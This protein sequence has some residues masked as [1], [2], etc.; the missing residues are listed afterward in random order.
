[1]AVLRVK[2]MMHYTGKYFAAALGYGVVRGVYYTDKV[3]SRNDERM[4]F[5]TRIA[6]VIMCTCMAPLFSPYYLVEDLNHVDE[7]FFLK[8]RT[9]DTGDAFPFPGFRLGKDVGK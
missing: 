8:K 5:G 7:R 4:L 2:W 1:M 9:A 3:R 6:Y